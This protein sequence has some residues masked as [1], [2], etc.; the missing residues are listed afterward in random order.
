MTWLKASIRDAPEVWG[1]FAVS[2]ALSVRAGL[3]TPAFCN[4]DEAAHYLRAFEVRRLHLL[5]RVGDARASMRCGEYLAVT[6]TCAPVA[7]FQ[8]AA[9]ERAGVPDCRVPT[10]NTAGT[11]PPVPYAVSALLIWIGE[12]RHWGVGSKLAAARLGNG[13]M[14]CLFLLFGLL[15]VRQFRI[16]FALVWLW[17]MAFWQRSALSTDWLLLGSSF[18]FVCWIV[19]IVEGGAG[20]SR[21]DWTVL[22]FMAALIGSTKSPYVFIGLSTFVLFGRRPEGI[23][24]WVWAAMLSSP[25]VVAAAMAMLWGGLADPALQYLGNGASPGE[26]AAFVLTHPHNF[27]AAV[28]KGLG[29][30]GVDWLRQMIGGSFTWISESVTG[31]ITSILTMACLSLLVTQSNP[32][33]RSERLF[34]M[35]SFMLLSV[36][37][38][39]FPLYLIYNP[40][41]YAGVLGVQGRNFIPFCPLLL[42]GAAVER[43]QSILLSQRT[44]SFLGIILPI[45][46]IVWVSF[47]KL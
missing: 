40:V 25:F 13:V 38:V 22:V 3:V 1:L 47:V 39:L 27:V 28:L 31:V 15:G 6:Q 20:G 33:S 23:S 41:G 8:T 19:K 7:W 11:Y 37:S 10:T 14:A 24:R 16:L 45:A 30:S 29:D 44:R 42:A 26:Q 18:L 35:G 12:L 5:N 43:K 34:L 36:A 46:V 17:P 9:A 2:V 4:P 21:K 32:F